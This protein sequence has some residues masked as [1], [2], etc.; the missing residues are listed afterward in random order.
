MTTKK[1]KIGRNDHCPCGSG[2]KYKKC[3]DDS[4]KG[5]FFTAASIPP[6]IASA[7][8]KAKA[9]ELIRIQ[10]QGL[11]KPIISQ[12][13]A[14]QQFVAVGNKLYHSASWKTVPD[15]LSD[16]LK[17]TLGSEWG[18]AEIAKPLEK[19]HT[20]LQWYDAYCQFQRQHQK[21]KGEIV[22]VQPTGIVYCYLG[23]AYNLYLL[24]HNIEL[25]S[26]LVKR[27]KE[28]SDFQGAYYELIVANILIR[29][30][31]KLELEDE[32]NSDSKHCEFS[33]ISTVTNKKYWV[34]A[35]MRSVVGYFGKD[36]KNGTTRK[37]PTVMLSKHLREA[38]Q[39]P[40]ADERLIFIDINAEPDN[41]DRKPDWV[42][43]VA[44]KL[45]Q[46]ESTKGRS[47]QAY[48]FVTNTPFH[49]SLDGTMF[50]HSIM[51][52]GLGMPDF[53]RPGYYR[54]Q[55]LYRQKKKHIDAHNILQTFKTY[56]QLPTTFDGSLPSISFGRDERLIIGE[57]YHF[58]GNDG[59][60]IIGT[61]T[62]ATVS[63][64]EKNIIC[65]VQVRNGQSI[66]LKKPM[67]EEEFIDYKKHPDVYFGRIQPAPRRTDDPFELYEFFIEAYKN[68][69][70]E[71]LFELIKDAPDLDRL[72]Q[73]SQDDLLLEICERWV[74]S[75]RAAAVK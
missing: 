29:S 26:R 47:D 41:P 60:G 6:E 65:A 8:E 23:L 32:T 67:S 1:K 75:A 68:T 55:D 45:E 51:A 16:Y 54:F 71:R 13:F 66:I 11:G 7:L 17:N 12:K 43:K 44:K 37:D 15:F 42:E 2:K 39:K 57:T 21:Q 19:R 48:V 34:E 46:R 53:G 63:E 4:L 25:Q 36:K 22:S 61:V 70:R 69:P 72:K 28:Q 56:T 49:R 58:D 14:G 74:A 31:F 10:Q 3:C 9:D 33:A 59:N 30:G 50:G 18:N 5:R 52:H 35:K 20:L 40:A 27:L 24:E 62:A 73:M 64:T 38:L